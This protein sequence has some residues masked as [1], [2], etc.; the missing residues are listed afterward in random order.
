MTGQDGIKYLENRGAGCPH[1]GGSIE[2]GSMSFESGEIC[3]QISCTDCGEEWNDIYKLTAITTLD[4]GLIVAV[5]IPV[6]GT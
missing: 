5:A 1:C 4:G 6:E 2:G 3:Q